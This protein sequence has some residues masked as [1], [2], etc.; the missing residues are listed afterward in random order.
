MSSSRSLG[1]ITSSSSSV[2]RASRNARNANSSARCRT[3]FAAGQIGYFTGDPATAAERKRGVSFHR[4]AGDYAGKKNVRFAVEALNR[5][6]MLP[7][8]SLRTTGVAFMIVTMM[9]AQVLFLVTIYL[10]VWTG[11]DPGHDAA[12]ALYESSGFTALPVVH[13]Y[14][15]L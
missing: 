5:F 3:L 11:G 6:E 12:R 15:E 13:Y 9:F 10:N 2:S 14:R 7:A 4:K 8:R 1:A